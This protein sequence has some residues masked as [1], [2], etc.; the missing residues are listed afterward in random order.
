MVPMQFT[1]GSIA[2]MPRTRRQLHHR[3]DQVD[4]RLPASAWREG[5]RDLNT[6]V[7]STELPELETWLGQLADAHA[8]Q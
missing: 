6:L 8:M 7:F 2:T 5:L 4:L 3:R 1:S